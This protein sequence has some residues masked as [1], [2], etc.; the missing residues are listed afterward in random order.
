MKKVGIV[1]LVIAALSSI[2]CFSIGFAEWAIPVSEV[3]VNGG[4]IT[5]DHVSSGDVNHNE[6]IDVRSVSSF[7]YR[8]GY[9]FNDPSTSEY[10]DTINITINARFNREKAV[11]DGAIASLI[12]DNKMSFKIDVSISNTPNYISSF[13]IADFPITSTG[14]SDIAEATSVIKTESSIYKEW[15]IG[16]VSSKENIPF[17]ISFKM[18]YTGNFASLPDFSTNKIMITMLPGEYI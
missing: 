14:F 6:Y 12:N 17:S 11:S 7:G 8:D 5:D 18:K 1:S 9:G 3:D 10:L 16:T 2:A 15:N 4:I 13:T